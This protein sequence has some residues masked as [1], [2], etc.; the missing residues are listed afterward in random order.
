[1]FEHGHH[2]RGELEFYNARWREQP[3]YILQMIRAYL[4]VSEQVDPLTRR[5]RL[6]A[7]RE[8]LTDQCR[9]R[10]RNPLKRCW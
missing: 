1:M 4:R 2:G 8:D 9:R 3:D 7:E 10:L 6:I 5:D